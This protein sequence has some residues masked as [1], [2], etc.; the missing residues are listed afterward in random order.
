MPFESTWL[1]DKHGRKIAPHTLVD[2]LGNT[3]DDVNEPADIAPLKT[4]F[5][6]RDE[7]DPTAF[8][9]V[10][11]MVSGDTNSAHFSKLSATVKN[12]RYLNK[13]LEKKISL[14]K[15]DEAPTDGS[16][17]WIDTSA[18][19][20]FNIPEIDDNNVSLVDTWSSAKIK[21]MI[22][23]AGVIV[24][25]EEYN[26]LTEEEKA[27]GTYF[28][29][30]MDV[31]P[32]AAT[33]DYDNGNSGIKAENAQDAIDTALSRPVNNNMLINSNFANPVNQRGYSSN[34]SAFMPE[35]RYAYVLDRWN[36][37]TGNNRGCEL[38]LND[39]YITLQHEPSEKVVNF[40]MQVVEHPQKYRGKTLTAS[41]KYRVS[42][43]SNID[44]L[45]FQGYVDTSDGSV[46]LYS[47]SSPDL[48]PETYHQSKPIVDGEWHIFTFTFTVPDIDN[49]TGFVPFST[50]IYNLNG[51]TNTNQMDIEWV[52]LELGSV[53]T[54]Y[55][56]R[57]YAEEL[58]LCK[59]Y[60]QQFRTTLT[61]P[62]ATAENSVLAVCESFDVPMRDVP[63]WTNFN[64]RNIGYEDMG[65][66][67]LDVNCDMYVSAYL[68]YSKALS[69]GS[70][71]LFAWLDAE[72]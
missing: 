52:K 24:T 55:V 41:A 27:S 29:S 69:V 44:D 12:T 15:G 43:G 53:A 50:G 6:N 60:F 64:I 70:Y 65:G 39:K 38:I 47:A 58:V 48:A 33:L 40:M 54:P 37:Y 59:R 16:E 49:I 34:L 36:F 56:P 20:T 72:L 66:T 51:S 2:N 57:L 25:M 35:G 42:N 63:T 67:L 62:V 14:H 10:E 71:F 68:Q 8:E 22:D 31:V 5:D 46:Y 17:L 32:N 30:D 23:D 18:G 26:N 28:I 9:N 19:E 45:F 61:I 11:E 21:E 13:E 7:A 4:C 1:Y 3:V